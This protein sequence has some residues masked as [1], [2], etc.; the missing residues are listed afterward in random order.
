MLVKNEHPRFGVDS[1]YLGLQSDPFGPIL[2]SQSSWWDDSGGF[3]D[4]PGPNSGF[5][6]GGFRSQNLDSGFYH[7][8]RMERTFG[9]QKIK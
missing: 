6:F 1:R 5:D 2:F 8:S 4:S 9:K 7:C 3:M